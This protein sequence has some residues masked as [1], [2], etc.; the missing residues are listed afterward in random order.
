MH[1]LMVSTKLGMAKIETKS[2]LCMQVKN[3]FTHF[4]DNLLLVVDFFLYF[5]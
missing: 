1:I 2:F 3:N 5:A 4:L